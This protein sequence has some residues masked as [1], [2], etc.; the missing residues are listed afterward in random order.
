MAAINMEGFQNE[1]IDVTIGNRKFI[2]PVDLPVEPYFEFMAL[3]DLDTKDEKIPEG[4]TE[5]E[6]AKARSVNIEKRKTFLKK[7]TEFCVDLFKRTNDIPESELRAILG[8]QN[9]NEFLTAYIEIQKESG[10]LKNLIKKAD[11]KTKEIQAQTQN[12]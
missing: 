2:I 6:K 9:I 5:E 4:A 3:L 1:T 10:F 11:E 7:A 12:Q 8:V